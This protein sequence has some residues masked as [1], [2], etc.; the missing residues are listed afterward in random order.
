MSKRKLNFNFY[1]FHWEAKEDEDEDELKIYIYGFDQDNNNVR[2][3]ANKFTPFIYLQLPENIEWTKSKVSIISNWITNKM[4]N[5]SPVQFSLVY[6]KKL[7]YANINEDSGETTLYP[8]LFISFK[9]EKHLKFCDGL[10][11]KDRLYVPGIG[12]YK[13]QV[14]EQNVETIIKFTGIKKLPLAG[15]INVEGY[16]V[17]PSL[18][19]TDCDIEVECNWKKL[20]PNNELTDVVRP[21]ILSLDGEMY[22]SKYPA[23]PDPEI[24]D[25]VVFQIGAT[26]AI[27][28]N[29]EDKYEKFLLT[30]EPCGDIEGVQFLNL[31]MKENYL[32]V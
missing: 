8:F 13:F 12:R 6:K 30:L 23:M 20:K 14:H 27:Q 9:T 11:H 24:P 19:E 5:K 32:T 22:A 3:T 17:E 1:A 25:D 7:Y 4:G 15:W 18:T 29:N 31:K 28:G 21:K 2:I 26:L 16:I 10:F